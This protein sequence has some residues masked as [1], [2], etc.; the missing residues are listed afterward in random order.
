MTTSTKP[1]RVKAR[2]QDYYWY[3]PVLRTALKDR[4]ADAV[5]S[6]KSEAEVVAVMRECFALGVPITPRGAGTGNYR[7][8]VPLRGG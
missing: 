3:S 8:A 4:I 1:G 5:V 2:S 6:P 7:Q